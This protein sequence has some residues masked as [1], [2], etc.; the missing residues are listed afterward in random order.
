VDGEEEERVWSVWQKGDARAAEILVLVALDYSKQARENSCT[1]KQ[2]SF[3]DCTYSPNNYDV[4]MGQRSG[5]LS[6]LAHML[7]EIYMA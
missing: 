2:Q 7:E 4:R 1:S 6:A 3:D 5:R